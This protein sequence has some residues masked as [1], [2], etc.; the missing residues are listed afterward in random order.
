MN[1]VA[2]I[3][4]RMDSSRFPGK[5]LEKIHGMPMIGHC[6]LRT[7]LCEQLA[8][9]YVATCDQEIYDYVQSLGGK[10][11]MTSDSHERA[12]DRTAEAMTFIENEKGEKVDIVV[13]VQGDEPMVHPD[14]I[15]Q[16]IQPLIND[17]SILVSNLLGD[18]ENIQEFNDPNCIKVVCDKDNNALYFSR[19]PIP[20]NS[21]RSTVTM[22]KQI[23]VIP[24]KRDF[25]FEYLKM[26]ST[27]LEIAESIDMLRIIENGYKVHMVPTNHITYAVDTLSDLEKVEPFLR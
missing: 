17:P 26:D 21:L 19:E 18:I 16:A 11:V 27:P 5:P 14:M 13:M 8:G 24:F 6:L 12:S 4:A 22:K 7:Q 23:C 10:A 2:I 9:T 1:I 15:T 25:L 20:T 3:P